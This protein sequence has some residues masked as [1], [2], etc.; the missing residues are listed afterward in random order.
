MCYDLKT[1][2]GELSIPSIQDGYTKKEEIT[3]PEKE[4]KW[5]LNYIFDN[6]LTKKD[7][8]LDDS[9]RKFRDK[10]L[11]LIDFSKK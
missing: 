7:D 3:N 11:N 8:E 4:I 10:F 2:C 5:Y 9:D 1:I 6:Y